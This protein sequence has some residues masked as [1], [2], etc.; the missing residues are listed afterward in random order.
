MKYLILSAFVFLNT[1]A[2]AG[3]EETLD[4]CKLSLAI[5]IEKINELNGGKVT[6]LGNWDGRVD[7]KNQSLSLSRFNEVS[8]L[9]YNAVARIE[10]N[11]CIISE[12]TVT[13]AD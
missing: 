3:N 13:T 9:S 6:E 7:R 5:A 11:K 1:N 12:V 10:K 8:L 4:A 2:F